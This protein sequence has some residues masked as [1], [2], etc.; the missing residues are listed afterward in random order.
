MPQV[1]RLV[2]G[3][4][5]EAV[6]RS[7]G[8]LPGL[9]WFPTSGTSCFTLSYALPQVLG[10]SPGANTEAVQRSYRRAL[11]DANR[12]DDKARIEKIESAHS[13][14]MMAGLQSRIKVRNPFWYPRW[15]EVSHP[16]SQA[17]EL[18]QDLV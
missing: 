6:L 17:A 8:S 1:L 16:G 15:L 14:I 18:T 3:T 11:N 13:R 10:L 2:T 4:K 9:A 5:L 7:S 12:A